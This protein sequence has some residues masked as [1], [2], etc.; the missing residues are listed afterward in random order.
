M[1]FG[2]KDIDGY[3]NKIELGIVDEI[4]AINELL[5]ISFLEDEI[6]K[7]L[8]VSDMSSC[9]LLLDDAAHAFSKE[10]QYDFFEFTWNSITK[11]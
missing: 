2:K 8:S 11:E 4:N 5:T 7:I 3:I 10:Q 6:K 1:I 9:V